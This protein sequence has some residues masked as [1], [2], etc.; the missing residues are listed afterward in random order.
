[1]CAEDI[2]ALLYVR[3]VFYIIVFMAVFGGFRL[4]TFTKLKCKDFE[5]SFICDLDDPVY[6]KL[7]VISTVNKN[8]IK[9][10]QKISQYKI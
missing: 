8:K 7:V 2:F 1:M 4:G 6:Y 9:K 3:F 10:S 5:L